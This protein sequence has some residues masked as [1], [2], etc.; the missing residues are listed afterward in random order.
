[1]NYEGWEAKQVEA[2]CF[3]LGSSTP[4]VVGWFRFEASAVKLAGNRRRFG[5][6]LGLRSHAV[7]SSF[8]RW[9]KASQKCETTTKTLASAVTG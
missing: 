1:M 8:N 6:R 5:G 7:E 2:A 4:V 9:P 3:G